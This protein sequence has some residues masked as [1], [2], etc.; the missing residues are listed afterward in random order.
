M[1]YKVISLD[2]LNESPV[3]PSNRP[4]TNYLLEAIIRSNII[5]PPIVAQ[6]PIGSY[7]LMDGHRRVDVCK[8]MMK[9][10]VYCCVKQVSSIQEVYVYTALMNSGTSPWKGREW[11]TG[12]AELKTAHERSSFL[13]SIPPS[14]QTN[15]RLMIST[16]GEEFSIVV[17]QKKN[18]SPDMVKYVIHMKAVLDMFDSLSDTTH[19][20]IATWIEKHSCQ[21]AVIAKTQRKYKHE[22]Y[23]MKEL[24]DDLKE[25]RPPA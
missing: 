23:V 21:S 5:A 11:L 13:N 17:G 6:L 1:E 2:L 15:I 9:T 8:K 16:F 3:Q 18:R 7:H 14:F 19:L 24:Y 25:D 20:E 22:F 4:G 10:E 12:W